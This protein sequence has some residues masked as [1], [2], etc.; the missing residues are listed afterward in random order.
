MRA[1]K[2]YMLHETFFWW[3]CYIKLLKYCTAHLIFM[4]HLKLSI[5]LLISILYS[6]K[7]YKFS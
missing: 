7:E 1:I 3:T 5:V 4:K 6:F 2:K